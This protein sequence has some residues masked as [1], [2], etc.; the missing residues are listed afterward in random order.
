MTIQQIKREI[1]GLKQKMNC[2]NSQVE[3]LLSNA[4]EELQKEVDRIGKRLRSVGEICVLSEAEQNELFENI[5]S[6]CAERTEDP[7]FQNYIRGF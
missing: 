3:Y 2:R 7:Y 1:E 6:S 5:L 4:K